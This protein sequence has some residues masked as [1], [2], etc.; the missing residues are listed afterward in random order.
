MNLNQIIAA[1]RN[2]A[3]LTQQEAAD[4]IG[5]S[6]TTLKQLETNK[7]LTFEKVNEI[8]RAYNG[9]AVPDEVVEQACEYLKSLFYPKEAVS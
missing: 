7:S 3:G 6:L 4:L 2:K 1:Q 9:G 8:V 5:V